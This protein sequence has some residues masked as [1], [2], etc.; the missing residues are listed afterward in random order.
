[1]TKARRRSQK[2]SATTTAIPTGGI[3]PT[4]LI[5]GAIA[6]VLL[7]VGLIVLGYQTTEGNSVAVASV[8][9]SD[10]PS[11]GPEDAPVTIVEYSDYNC[12]HCRNFNLDTLPELEAAYKDSGNVRYILHPFYLGNPAVAFAAEAALCAREQGRF[13]DYHHALFQNQG[14][15]FNTANL[16]NLAAEMGFD[17]DDFAACLSSNRYRTTIEEARRAAV[18]RGINST[19]TF[20]INDQRVEGN[21]PFS[22]MQNVIEQELAIAQ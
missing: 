8:D 11:W 6:A 18:N 14:M 5:G 7:V 2:T 22:V 13:F 20:F 4:I 16:V 15:S 21:Q 17:R 3:S 19:P 1:M 12:P 9:P 10:F